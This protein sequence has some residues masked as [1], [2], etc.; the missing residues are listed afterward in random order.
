MNN[1]NGR[2]IMTRSLVIFLF[3]TGGVFA[4]PDGILRGTLKKI[5]ADKM[6]VTI[7][8]DGKDKDYR[9]GENTRVF[10][11]EGKPFKER[12]AGL[13]EGTPVMFKPD[14]DDVLI[15]LRAGDTP[16]AKQIAKVDTSKLK[17]LTELGKEE[18]KGF[19]GGLYPD[20]AT[21]RPAAHEKAGLAIEIGR[22][23][24]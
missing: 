2:H 5:D 17:P 23:H 16:A 7:T 6:T 12:L 4:Q 10:G 22:A 19:K 18:Y 1:W 24:V 15:G 21:E 20:G 11:N 3:L 14:K 9:I 13:K 8:H